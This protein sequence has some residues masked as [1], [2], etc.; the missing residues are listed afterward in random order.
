MIDTALEA[1]TYTIF[2][3][4]VDALDMLTG[5]AAGV[6]FMI[7]DI[8]VTD[9]EI[10]SDS[11]QW[12]KTSAEGCVIEYSRDE[13]QTALAVVATGSAVDVV[14]LTGGI[15]Q[16]RA[17]YESTDIWSDS[18]TVISSDATAASTQF[19]SNADGVGDIFF[20]GANGTWQGKYA[21]RNVGSI[22]DWSG[23]GEQVRLNGKNKIA[24]I[25]EGSTDA[26]ILV[27]TDDA[28]GDALFVD[29]IYTALPGSIA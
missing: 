4:A 12:K 15:Y 3:E 19:V 13:F 20:A 27:L 23:T 11:I 14:N 25:F 7:S 1:G 18:Q 10:S 16:V 28:N 5:N 21:A 29:D 6:S 24:D 22:N 2:A 26:N 17:K 9:L 8:A